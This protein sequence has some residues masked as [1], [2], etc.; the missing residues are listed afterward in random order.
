MWK[1]TPPGNAQ[2]WL[3]KKNDLP[4]AP[5]QFHVLGI[6]YPLTIGKM[7]RRGV[8]MSERKVGTVVQYRT[9]KATVKRS[10]IEGDVRKIQV[11]PPFII[12]G[13]C[14]SVLPASEVTTVS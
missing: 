5:L 4:V 1:V 13:V 11:T 14:I 7:T 8:R 2:R 9:Q 3:K 6:W 10:F 12:Q